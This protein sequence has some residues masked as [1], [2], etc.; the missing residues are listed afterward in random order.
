MTGNA[1]KKPFEQVFEG[2]YWPERPGDTPEI[3]EPVVFGIGTADVRVTGSRTAYLKLRRGL[4]AMQILGTVQNMGDCPARNVTIAVK[5]LNGKKVVWTKDIA[6]KASSLAAKAT[7]PFSVIVNPLPNHTSITYHVNF[8]SVETKEEGPVTV[9][10][11]DIDAGPLLIKDCYLNPKTGLFTGTLINKG[12]K[13]LYD[14]IVN[15]NIEKSGA[16]TFHKIQLGGEIKPGDSFDLIKATPP[17]FDTL[18]VDVGFQE[19]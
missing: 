14:V 6:I 16:T 5:M 2:K 7:A 11:F 1:A 12:G 19:K 3:P 18:G 9:K 17:G 15:I 8:D 4:E 13:T 10:K